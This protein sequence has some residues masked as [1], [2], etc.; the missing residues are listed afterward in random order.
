[1]HRLVLASAS[2]RRH[3]LLREH[4]YEFAAHP[5]EVDEVMAEF[6]TVGELV[7]LNAVKK[8]RAASRFHPSA[9][10]L[11]ADTLVSLDGRT[12]GKPADY[13]Q[14]REM[15]G[16]LS[17]K[18]HQVFTGLALTRKADGKNEFG[19]EVTNVEFRPLTPEAIDEYL[20]VV[21][22]LDKAGAYAAQE[23]GE[24]VIANVDGSWTNV[25]GLPMERLK[26]MLAK[27]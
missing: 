18:V 1:M 10:V 20:R 27:F 17:G 25:V 3:A 8:A 11:A 22:P 26:G 5:V 9:I 15:L 13:E 6:L 2:P 19:V 14:A 12:M 24:Q 23:F 16:A 21:D 4:S 7:L